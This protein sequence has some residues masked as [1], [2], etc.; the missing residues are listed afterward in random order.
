MGVVSSKSKLLRL[1]FSIWSLLRS[2]TLYTTAPIPLQVNITTSQQNFSKKVT[3]L[4]RIMG[5]WVYQCLMVETNLAYGKQFWKPII[6]QHYGTKTKQLPKNTQKTFRKCLLYKG[7]NYWANYW[8]K[9]EILTPFPLKENPSKLL[10]VQVYLYRNTQDDMD[11]NM[12]SWK[13]GYGTST[14]ALRNMTKAQTRRCALRYI[15]GT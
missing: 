9:V 3:K 2:G 8:H 15:R 4:T 12:R 6:P 10:L 13:Q 11:T 7:W 14:N 5:H 1:I